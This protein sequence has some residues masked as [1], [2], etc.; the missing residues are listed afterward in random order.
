MID[1]PLMNYDTAHSASGDVSRSD[2][3]TYGGCVN[4]Y[5][6]KSRFY[7]RF[8]YYGPC[9]RLKHKHIAGG[10]VG[11]GLSDAMASVVKTMIRTKQP[12][13][14]ILKAIM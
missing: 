7:W 10:S 14:A 3:S 5:Q 2:N 11:S 4:Q 8:S 13:E 6:K 1:L 12:I 9:G